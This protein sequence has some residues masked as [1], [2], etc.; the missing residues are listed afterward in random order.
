MSLSSSTLAVSTT[1]AISGALTTA[2]IVN[3]G[4]LQQ[5]GTA[6]FGSSIGVNGYATFNNGAIFNSS[7]PQLSGSGITAASIPISSLANGVVQTSTVSSTINNTATLTVVNPIVGSCTKVGI[8][9][10][11]ADANKCYFGLV[12]QG[13][14]YGLTSTSSV[15]NL[16]TDG[17][18]SYQP[19]T[20]TVYLPNVKLTSGSNFDGTGVLLNTTVNS[21]Q[22]NDRYTGTTGEFMWLSGH[23]GTTA[24]TPGSTYNGS[25]GSMITSL[26]FDTNNL[27]LYTNGLI[28]TN[29]GIQVAPTV[30]PPT[31]SYVGYNF[32]PVTFALPTT[33]TTTSV[34]IVGG[35][36]VLT[37]AAHYG[38][39]MIMVTIIPKSLVAN[40]VMSSN[41]STTVSATTGTTNIGCSFQAGA[42][43]SSATGMAQS[44]SYVYQYYATTSNL[45][46][47]ATNSSTCAASSGYYQMVRIA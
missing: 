32:A 14:A 44:Y 47:T 46:I 12:D 33:A 5:T 38:V 31:K 45:Y 9:D 41:I 24:P 42:A 6:S 21:L 4:T 17:F 8:A 43:A 16:I 39:W 30:T 15:Q 23:F 7:A 25:F 40:A 20:K 35:T 27:N 2:S 1:A 29:G 10:S 26:K 34:Q 37:T 11:S 28:L 22:V 3:G 19:S 18:I 36:G 13:A